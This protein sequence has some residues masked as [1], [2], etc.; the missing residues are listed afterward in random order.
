MG[1]LESK[2][3]S[4]LEHPE[5]IEIVKEVFDALDADHNGTISLDE[6]CNYFM[7]VY[8]PY[9]KIFSSLENIH[10]TLSSVLHDSAQVYNKQDYLGQFH[11]RFFL[12]EFLQQIESLQKPLQVAVSSMEA[13]S[14]Q[15]Y[16]RVRE[17]QVVV[18]NTT[19][20]KRFTYSPPVVQSLNPSGSSELEDQIH[21]LS[22]LISRLESSPEIQL[23]VSEEATE[24][25]EDYLLVTRQMKVKADPE[26]HAS[27]NGILRQYV[28]LSKRE[29]GFINCQIRHKDAEFKLLE[30]WKNEEAYAQHQVSEHSKGFSKQLA[31]LLGHPESTST[32]LLPSSWFP[33]A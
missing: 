1:T 8:P 20:T 22:S 5:D 17:Q 13:R 30:I 7:Q 2:V 15:Q 25:Q 16:N 4:A 23:S 26:S 32:S 29:P 18:E 19:K 12:R 28:K 27:F 6:L 11:I 21:R 31:D 24:N 10:E 14:L 3:N 33:S 9:K